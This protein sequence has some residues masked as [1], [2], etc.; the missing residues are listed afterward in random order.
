MDRATIFAPLTAVGRTAVTIV[1]LSG[2]GAGAALRTL[3]AA[4]LPPPRRA[5]LRTLSVPASGDPL[6][7]AMVLWFPHPASFTGEDV[8]ELH[9]HGGRAVAGGVLD[10]LAA[11][12]GLRLA[13]PGEFSRRAFD[14]G[15]LDLT[16]AEAIADLVD[17]E[18]QAQHR[19]ALRQLDGALGR[20]VGRWAD[21]LTRALAYLEASLDFPDEDLPEDLFARVLPGLAELGLEIEA[22]LADAGRGE[23]L[24][25][26]FTVAILGAPNAGKSSLLN[27]L[28]RR[29][30]AIVSDRAGTTRDVIE[31]HLDL[32]GLP[33]ILADTAGLR[34][35]GDPV[36]DEGVRRARAHA[37]T[38]DMR[39]L[40]FDATLL[41]AM[42]AGT[43]GLADGGSLTVVSKTD[44]CP[45]LSADAGG[46]GA[47]Q[48][49]TVTG[50]GLGALTAC[51][52]DRAAA[53]I[54]G[55]GLITRARHREAFRDCRDALA[56]AQ[57]APSA[58]L[59][60]EDVRLALR[61]LGRVTG[62]VDVEALLDVI[63][64]DFCI[65]K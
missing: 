33:V 26:G 17:A 60:A 48:V 35:S 2:P 40:V 23:R 37:A 6:D 1:R 7:R 43:A 3:S 41:P 11:M 44:L 55:A 49:S 30:V 63:F 54:G 13:Q 16:E 65:G 45:G 18:T 9:L 5:A 31:V 8:V 32:D 10:A 59:V 15:K 12:D 50:A 51:L 61:A 29:D 28:A 46:P 64:R 36:E 56:R 58:E 39:L 25:N 57:A 22:Q 53:A 24:R 4:P 21:G 14:S 20:T 27:A 34:D 62:T 38:A 47:V 52:R 19:Q 42:D